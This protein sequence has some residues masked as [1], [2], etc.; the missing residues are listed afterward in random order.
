MK[1]TKF[2]PFMMLSVVLLASCQSRES[3]INKL[4]TSHLE[5]SLDNPQVLAFSKYCMAFYNW[6]ESNRK[7]SNEPT[8]TFEKRNVCRK[9]AKA[10]FVPALYESLDSIYG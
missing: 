6:L 9:T 3:K 5:Q 10:Y 8:N 7:P 4:V 1:I 2:I